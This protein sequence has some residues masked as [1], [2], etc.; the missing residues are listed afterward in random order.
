MNSFQILSPR[1][2]IDEALE[3]LGMSNMDKVMAIEALLRITRDDDLPLYF[4]KKL[5]CVP[6]SMKYGDQFDEYG[7]YVETRFVNPEDEREFWSKHIPYFY[8]LFESTGQAF[9]IYVGGV[10]HDGIVYNICAG[11]RRVAGYIS[12]EYDQ[13]YFDREQLITFKAEYAA[14]FSA[15]QPVNEIY[16]N[17]EGIQEQRIT[18]FK[19]WLV[20]NSGKSIHNDDDLQDCYQKLG[21]PTRE[22]VIS[23]LLQM[24][25]GLFTQGKDDFKKA[26]S[27]VIQ[28][29]TGTGKDR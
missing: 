17:K 20:G 24:D 13:F 9:S 18:A 4:D 22:Q 23:R 26:M 11:N 25:K 5:T 2:S 10:I 7:K 12:I 16:S 21:S 3:F 19:Y 6:E 14:H 29:K 27:K 15:K 1:P 8:I 28:F